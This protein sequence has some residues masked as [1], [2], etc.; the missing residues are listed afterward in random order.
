[1]IQCFGTTAPDC[2]FVVAPC[3]C[4]ARREVA[5]KAERD[6]ANKLLQAHDPTAS[7]AT[8]HSWLI[9]TVPEKPVAGEGGGRHTWL[10]VAYF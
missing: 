2:T 3:V 4:R 7:A 5:K 9:Y 1:M 6:A 10:L 8:R